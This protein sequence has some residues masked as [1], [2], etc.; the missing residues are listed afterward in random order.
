MHRS[1]IRP[2]C[3]LGRTA[4]R[5]PQPSLAP[6]SLI[7]PHNAPRRAPLRAA[8]T[9]T[10]R[11]MTQARR[12]S[13]RNNEDEEGEGGTYSEADH[14]HAVISTFDLFSIGIG[15]S[16]SH[17]VGP[18]R[19]GNIFI[20][21]LIEAGLLQQV[22]RIRISLYGS[23]ALTGEGHM[24]PSALLL[25]LESANVESV[26]TA[27]VPE[28][29]IEIKEKKKL[30]LGHGLA[31]GQGKEISFDYDRDFTWEWGKKLPLHSN[32]MRFR[33]FDKDGYM[34]ATNDLF[35]VGGGFVV[36]GSLSINPENSP[37]DSPAQGSLT[38]T[39]EAGHPADLA[40]NMFYKEIRRADAAGDRKT[41]AEVKLL[42]GSSAESAEAGVIV[43]AGAD[44]GSKDSPSLP[45]SDD[46]EANGDSKQPRY[47]FRDASSLLALCK[48][49]NLT[50][51]QLVYENEKSHGYTDDEIHDKVFR[52]WETMDH[53][54]LEGVQA[55]SD[56]VLPGSLKLHR[57]APALYSRLTRGLYPSHTSRV[58]GEL[59]S[60]SGGKGEKPAASTTSKALSRSESAIKRATP[61]RVHGS[62]YHPVMPSPLRRT[63]FP[64]MDHL[65]VYAMGKRDPP[66]TLY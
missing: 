25:G 13:T 43:H 53:S 61:P 54:I 41:G 14:E 2:L 51:A 62:L 55:P 5:S 63:T 6:L 38:G 4:I 11:H 59:A 33:V 12:Y 8:T 48:K 9:A 1:V 34:I 28:R 22:D 7:A 32:G 16:S 27:Y 39:N 3:L 45:T 44:D 21:D 26:D 47:A 10:S 30:Y 56:A 52:I 65:S 15:P 36:N 49:H 20:T 46:N 37:S 24:T 17:T 60:S 31:E 40:E 19:A 42:D 35:S 18:M 23:L 66:P 64:A 50:I 29:F 58:S 57:R